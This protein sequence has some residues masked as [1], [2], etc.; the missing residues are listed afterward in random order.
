MKNKLCDKK[1]G[2][3]WAAFIV[4]DWKPVT[5]RA[6]QSSVHNLSFLQY[7]YNNDWDLNPGNI[8][9]MFLMIQALLCEEKSIILQVA[10]NGLISWAEK[11]Q[12]QSD[13]MKLEV[14]SLKKKCVGKGAV[15]ILEILLCGAPIEASL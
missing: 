4:C 2:V 1:R 12:M 7:I 8:T 13:P 11:W 6:P 10:D 5:R 15:N 3:I 14:I 9:K